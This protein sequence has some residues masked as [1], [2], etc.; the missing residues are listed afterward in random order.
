[1][2]PTRSAADT[3][4]VA[5]RELWTAITSIPVITGTEGTSENLG[6]TNSS[7]HISP[8]ELREVRRCLQ[9]SPWATPK[10]C[11]DGISTTSI[12]L[13]EIE[14][15]TFRQSGLTSTSE[16]SWITAPYG[17]ADWKRQTEVPSVYFSDL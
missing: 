6:R 4:F 17:R 8:E 2:G 11:A 5:G 9:N 14:R 3:K 1:M 15:S 7:F 12:R 10:R 13:E 16:Y